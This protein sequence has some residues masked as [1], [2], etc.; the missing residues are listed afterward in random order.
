MSVEPK[1]PSSFE[2][3]IAAFAFVVSFAFAYGYWRLA[4]HQNEQDERIEQQRDALEKSLVRLQADLE[5]NRAADN[6][7]LQV[8]TLVA[9]HLAK[10]RETGPQAVASQRIVAAAAVL[11]AAR[12]RP[13]LRQM[14][15]KIREHGAPVEGPDAP[16]KIEA[17]PTVKLPSNP[18]LVLL[19][20]LPGTDLKAAEVVANEKLRAAKDLGLMPFVSVYKTKLKGRYVVALGKP[21]ERSEALAAAAQARQRNLA[22]DA[23]AEPDGGWE[24]TGTAPF[25][26]G[27]ASASASAE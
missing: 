26:A 6:L 19:A 23:F 27:V 7:E 24:L 20:T 3:V 2:A 17:S 9:P 13:G 5:S 14:A 15:E 21:A 18:W 4:T 25:P 10:L 8:I 1:K 12:G 22:T 16:A 11:L